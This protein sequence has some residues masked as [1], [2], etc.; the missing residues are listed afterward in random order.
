MV[1]DHVLNTGNGLVNRVYLDEVWDNALSKIV[2]SLRTPSVRYFVLI[3]FMPHKLI[4]CELG[5]K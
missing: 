1:E 5:I 4:I 2:A 3:I